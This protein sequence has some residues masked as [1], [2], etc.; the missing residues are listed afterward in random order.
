MENWKQRYK[1]LKKSM[2]WTNKDI[3]EMIGLTLNSVEVMT[4]TE[5]D[6]PKWAKLAILTHES[7][8]EKG[9][10]VYDAKGAQ[11]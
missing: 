8:V 1:A 6:F 7:M 10:I 9:R 3:A 11:N 2:N 5:S 4:R